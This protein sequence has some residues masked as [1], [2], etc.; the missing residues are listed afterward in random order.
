VNVCVSFPLSYHRCITGE[1]TLIHYTEDEYAKR[2]IGNTFS[3]PVLE[4]LLKP[5]QNV[6]TKANYDGYDYQYAWSMASTQQSS[7]P[8]C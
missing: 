1:K 4:E 5:L 3:I 6:F 2:L 7:T 8:T